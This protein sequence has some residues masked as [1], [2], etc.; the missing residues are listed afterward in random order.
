MAKGMNKGAFRGK[1]ECPA[2]VNKNGVAETCGAEKWKF[3]EKIGPYRIRYKCKVCGSTC[4]YDFS[5]NPQHPYEVFGK[6]KWRTIVDRYKASQ[7]MR[8]LR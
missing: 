2:L 4:Q 8:P 7:G 1:L 5:A 6:G 3:V